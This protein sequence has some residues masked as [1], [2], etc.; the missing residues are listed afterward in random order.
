[1]L[2]VFNKEKQLNI[3]LSELTALK[4][5]LK[6]VIFL[7][8]AILSDYESWASATDDLWRIINRVGLAS[9]LGVMTLTPTI[10][11]FIPGSTEQFLDV[12]VH[13]NWDKT[14]GEIIT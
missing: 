14:F 5:I 2:L 10:D 6:R 13:D 1:M 7:P 11:E 4:V 9:K 8:G 3:P 12:K